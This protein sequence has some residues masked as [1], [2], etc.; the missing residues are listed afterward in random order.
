MN[1]H[2]SDKTES[3]LDRIRTEHVYPPI[4][5]RDF[6]WRAT[7]DDYE[8]GCPIGE[9]PTEEAAIADLLSQIRDAE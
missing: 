9:G 8:P 5:I 6:D 7:L 2:Y 4:P 1:Q 3:L